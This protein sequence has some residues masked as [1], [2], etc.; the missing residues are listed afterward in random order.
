M[1]IGLAS[2]DQRWLD[3]DANFS[4]CANFAY[5]AARNACELV[6]FP[7]MTL[8]G[9]APAATD[10]AESEIDS[11]SLKRFGVLA[12]EAGLTIIFGACLLDPE[13]RRP[14][15]QLCVARPDGGCETVYAKIHPFSFAGEDQI[16]QAGARLG[17][18]S[19]GSLRFGASICYDL[20]F[21]ELYSAMSSDCNGAIA[22]ANWPARRVTHWRTLLVARAIENQFF[23]LG[24][25]RTGTDGNQLAYAK[26]TM[27]VAPDGSQLDPIVRGEE[28]D[29]YDIDPLEAARY[30]A[31]FPTVR[32]KRYALYREF[33]G[34]RKC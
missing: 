5:S 25:N 7:E 27:A 32:D 33:L 34:A 13:T 12:N 15:N 6:V 31:E 10:I 2:L 19:V 17:S 24:V 18:I 11:P 23:M 8:T 1:R 30:R 16:F 26:S 3:K 21:P 20:R 9:Y 22:I 14:R 4:R 29:I 28:L